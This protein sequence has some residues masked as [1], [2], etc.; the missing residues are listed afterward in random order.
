MD[1]I[2]KKLK[3]KLQDQ[4]S[5]IRSLTYVLGTKFFLINL[6]ILPF[7]FDLPMKL[8]NCIHIRGLHERY[9]QSDICIVRDH[10]SISTT[11]HSHS[12]SIHMDIRSMYAR[13]C[14]HVG[15][16]CLDAFTFI[17]LSFSSFFFE[18]VKFL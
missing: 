1:F 11:W 12:Y 4:G 10:R 16:N 18:L 17:R 2:E 13:I 15:I 14:S 3:Q 6:L 8:N 5:K 7:Q 9:S